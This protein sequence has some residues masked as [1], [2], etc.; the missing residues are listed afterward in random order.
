MMSEK[1]A[2]TTYDISG[3]RW[4]QIINAVNHRQK[5]EVISPPLD[6]VELEQFYRMEKQKREADEKNGYESFFAPVEIDFDD[7]CLDIYHEELWKR[8]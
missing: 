3:Y 4:N 8:K 2:K 5:P 7:P 6:E 1:R